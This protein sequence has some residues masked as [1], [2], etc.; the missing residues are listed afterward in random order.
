ML[1]PPFVEGKGDIVR[2]ETGVHSS[3]HEGTSGHRIPACAFRLNEQRQTGK[4][5]AEM[6]TQIGADHGK[7]LKAE[8]AAWYVQ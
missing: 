7:R 8:F 3:R 4:P 2:L 5:K 1:L 6:A